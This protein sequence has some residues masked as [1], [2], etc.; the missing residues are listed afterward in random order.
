M[1]GFYRKEGGARSYYQK[2]IKDSFRQGHF[3]LEGRAGVII[4]QMT[5]C[6]MDGEVPVT[7]YFI[8]AN[9]KIPD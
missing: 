8:S 3:P 6:W 2:K 4:M 5:S 1:E 7:D 9:Q